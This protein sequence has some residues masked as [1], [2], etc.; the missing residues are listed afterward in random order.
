MSQLLMLWTAPP[1]EMQEMPI[2][3]GFFEFPPQKFYRS[4]AH[5]KSLCKT[6][7]GGLIGSAAIG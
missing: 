6:D 1:H 3:R 7:L 2:K 5:G 4:L